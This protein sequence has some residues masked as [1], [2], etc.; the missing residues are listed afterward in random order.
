MTGVEGKYA[1]FAD[2]ASVWK[3]DKTIESICMK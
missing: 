2:D 1:E 3:S